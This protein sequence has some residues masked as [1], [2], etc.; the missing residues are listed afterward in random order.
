MTVQQGAFVVGM[1][2]GG[3]VITLVQAIFG[4]AIVPKSSD[5]EIAEKAMKHWKTAIDGWKEA[6]EV[7][8]DMAKTSSTLGKN[9]KALFTLFLEINPPVTDEQGKQLEKLGKEMLD[10]L[11]AYNRKWGVVSGR[12]DDLKARVKQNLVP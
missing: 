8:D 9:T 5:E 10:S 11:E 7:V 6:L 12:L 1:L 2:V 3:G 4:L